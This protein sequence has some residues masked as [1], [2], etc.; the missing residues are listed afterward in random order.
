MSIRDRLIEQL[1]REIQALKEELESF[2][3][4]VR[5]FLT[6]YVTHNTNQLFT[7]TA[8]HPPPPPIRVVACVR[9]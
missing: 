3:L 5:S 7:N 4:E 2:R 1:T 6:S 8:V 9:H